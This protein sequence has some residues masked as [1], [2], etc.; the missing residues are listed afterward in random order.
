MLQ[1]SELLE[2]NHWRS[3]LLQNAPQ[4]MMYLFGS[5]LALLMM[6]DL[7][8][9]NGFPLSLGT[10]L[11]WCALKKVQT[12]VSSKPFHFL[13]IILLD[14]FFFW[15]SRWDLLCYLWRFLFFSI[16]FLTESETRLTD[17]DY[18]RGYRV[19]FSDGYP[20]LITSQVLFFI[21][22]CSFRM[23][24]YLQ[25]LLKQKL[26]LTMQVD[27]QGSLDALNE[28]LEDPVPINRFRPKWATHIARLYFLNNFFMDN[29]CGW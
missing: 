21:L 20:F 5:G 13:K 27:F 29:W 8:Q 26:Y 2:W 28:K 17:P 7:K 11:D 3:L 23:K 4:S 15:N 1:L 6:K 14:N 10:Q 22:F 19:T 9:P 16:F 18:A 25:M 24:N 12:V